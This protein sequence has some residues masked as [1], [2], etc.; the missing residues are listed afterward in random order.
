MKTIYLSLAP[1]SNANQIKAALRLLISMVRLSH[2]TAREVISTFDFSHTC[3]ASILQRRSLTEVPD[4]RS[5][6]LIFITSFVAEEDSM[7]LRTLG[8]N[9]E[10]LQPLFEG[11]IYDSVRVVEMFLDNLRNFLA[12]SNLL[13]KTLKLRIFNSYTCQHLSRLYF[14]QGPQ[15]APKKSLKE[16]KDGKQAVK[17]D[18]DGEDGNTVAEAVTSL[19]MVL[20]TSHKFGLA[21]AD[22]SI[23][24]SGKNKNYAVYGLIMVSYYRVNDF[25]NYVLLKDIFIHGSRCKSSGSRAHLEYSNCFRIWL[26]KL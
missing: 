13:S 21:F 22:Y 25:Y 10:I 19:L 6:Y 3:V 17:I 20:C 14:W 26:W 16:D 23:G 9:R 4:V 1:S 15:K 8:E 12:S 5:T 7:L 2:I 24:L 18:D 11:L